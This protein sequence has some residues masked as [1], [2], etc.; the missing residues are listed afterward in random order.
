MVSLDLRCEMYW[1]QGDVKCKTFHVHF[2][3]PKFMIVC[4]C[5][6]Q[7]YPTQ[8]I[9]WLLMSWRRSRGPGPQQILYW[10]DSYGIFYSGFSTR[11]VQCYLSFYSQCVWKCVFVYCEQVSMPHLIAHIDGSPCILCFRQYICNSCI[12]SLWITPRILR[13]KFQNH[14]FLRPG[15]MYPHF[16]LV[17]FISLD[18]DCQQV[19]AV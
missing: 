2:N 18:G 19:S 4:F 12:D 7:V 14:G 3:F 15:H 6:S 1:V 17:D 16:I 11:R 13:W 8:S 10:P 9:A 5:Q